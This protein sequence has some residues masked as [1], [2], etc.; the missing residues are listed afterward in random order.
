MLKETFSA[1]EI[2]EVREFIDAG[3]YGLALETTVD[4][5]VEERKVAPQEIAVMIENLANAM[6]LTSVSYLNRLSI[7]RREP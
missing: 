3:E 1:S 4:I 2:A 7:S 6:Q 5:F